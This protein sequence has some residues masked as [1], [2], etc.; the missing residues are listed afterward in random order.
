[1]TP[2]PMVV[3]AVTGLGAHGIV[4]V[5]MTGRMCKENPMY[6]VVLRRDCNEIVR[7]SLCASARTSQ[8]SGLRYFQYGTTGESPLKAHSRHAMLHGYGCHLNHV[9]TMTMI[10]HANNES[11]HTVALR[12]GHG[13][14]RNLNLMVAWPLSSRV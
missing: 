9:L 14:V 6:K 8:E 12:C 7:F 1:M 11:N 5:T 10:E 3:A 13:K 2:S 4:D